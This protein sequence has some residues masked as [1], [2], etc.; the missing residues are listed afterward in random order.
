MLPNLTDHVGWHSPKL[1]K[2][3]TPGKGIGMFAVEPIER[4]EVLA[5]WGGYV[6]T[7]K[8]RHELP[9]EAE[10]HTIQIE[11]DLHLTSGLLNNSADYFN[12]S[13]DPNLGLRGQIA[14]VAMRSIGVGEEVTFDYAMSESDPDLVMECACGQSNCRQSITGN[15]WKLPELQERYHGYFSPYI[16]H[17]ID[18]QGWR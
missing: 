1:E 9:E 17:M 3:E 4:D 8:E 12:H 13:C 5:V 18:V 16:Q 6:V 15:D 7:T 2:R 11:N 10:H 14:L